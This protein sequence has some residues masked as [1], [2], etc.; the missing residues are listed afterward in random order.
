[1]NTTS[2][3]TNTTRFGRM[4]KAAAFGLALTAS[5][6]AMSGTAGAASSGEVELGSAL[7]ASVSMDANGVE[8]I[9]ITEVDLYGR[10]H[11]IKVRADSVVRISGIAQARLMVNLAAM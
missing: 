6:G 4:A 2:T 10:V 7:S 9:E 3:T 5:V 1:M 11:T 8:M